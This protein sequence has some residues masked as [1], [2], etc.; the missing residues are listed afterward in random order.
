MGLQKIF[1]NWITHLVLPLER[2]NLVILV[3]IE[4]PKEERPIPLDFYRVTYVHSLSESA[5]IL[6]KR[7]NLGIWAKF[8]GF[9]NDNRISLS[10]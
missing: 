2:V 3:V 10:P 9:D 4:P 1:A 8:Q 6:E 7:G 5:G